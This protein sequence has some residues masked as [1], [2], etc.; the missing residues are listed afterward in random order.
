MK[1]IR[2]LILVSLFA[3]MTCIL[4]IFLIPLPFTPVPITLQIVGVTLSGAILGAKLGFYS[5]GLYTLLGIVGLPVFAGGGSGFG[6]L[7]GPTGGYIFGF[8]AGAYVIGLLTHFGYQK[9]SNGK[10]SKYFIQLSAMAMGI[11][12]VYTFGTLQLMVVTG[13][14][15]TQSVATGTLPFLIPDLLKVSAAALVAVA[16]RD[17]LIKAHLISSSGEI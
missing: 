13:M 16:L 15:F 14:S 1:N 11:L 4:S 6:A 8:M 2:E 5:L 9:F 7:L 12:V 17:G 3:A 10:F